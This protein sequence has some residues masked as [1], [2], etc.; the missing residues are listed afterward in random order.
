MV[1]YAL[2][3]SIIDYCITSWGGASKSHLIEV[4]RAQRAL[5]K[6]GAGL[7]YRT[8]TVELYKDWDLLTVRQTFIMH[9]VIKKHLI[10]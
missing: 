5:L 2:A 6:V 10:N 7:P 9:I 8:P 1:Y 4:E 3:Q